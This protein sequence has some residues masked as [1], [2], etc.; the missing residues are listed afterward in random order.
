MKMKTKTLLSSLIAV[1]VGIVLFAPGHA[2]AAAFG[3]SPP[4]IENSNLRPGDNYVYVI[5]L[6]ATNLS[7]DMLV[8]S[9]L[10]GDPEIMQWLKIRNKDDLVMPKGE[11]IVPMSVE[12]SVPANAQVG[13]YEGSLKLSLAA[14]T[15]NTSNVAVLLGSNIKIDLDVVDYDVTDYWIRSISADPIIAG[16]PIGLKMDV[17]NLGNTVLNNVLTQV[18]LINMKTGDQVASGSVDQLDVPVHPHTMAE[19]EL[20]FLASDLEP[21]DYWLNVEAFKNNQSVYENRLFFQIKPQLANN[22]V[23]TDVE[24]SKDGKVKPAAIA[25]TRSISN[26]TDV[27]TTVKVRAPYTDKLIIVVIAILVILTGIVIKIYVNFS[28]KRRR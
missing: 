7:E 5:N 22:I 26:G 9:E 24:V 12:V 8:Q 3:V 19:A 18:S 10:H 20:S 11:K 1:F 4:W 28:K 15:S 16:Q 21:G 23:S 6:S 2:L 13:K 17:K 27:Q 14:K 25:E